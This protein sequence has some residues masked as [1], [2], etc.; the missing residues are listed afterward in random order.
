MLTACS[1]GV[2]SGRSSSRWAPS[3]DLLELLACDPAERDAR[4]ARLARWSRPR[5]RRGASTRAAIIRR[6]CATS[7]PSRSTSRAAA[8]SPAPACR[9]KWYQAPP[10]SLH[11][12]PLGPSAPAIRWRSRPAASGWTSSWRSRGVVG[13]TG[14]DVTPEQARGHIA[15]YTIF[16][17]WSARDLQA[18]EMQVGL[19]PAKAKDFASTLGPWIVTSDEL[20][21]F[22]ADDRLHLDMSAAI[23]GEEIGGD[24]PPPTWPWSFGGVCSPTPP[25]G[26]RPP[27]GTCSAPAPAAPAACS[28]YGGDTAPSSRRRS[29]R[30]TSSLEVEGIGGISN[31]IVAVSRRSRSP[32]PARPDGARARGTDPGRRRARDERRCRPK[33]AAR[34]QAL[35]SR[36]ASREKRG[37]H[38]WR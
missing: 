24:P 2:V 5:A 38:P 6:R 35:A 34:A 10:S 25:V 15:G 37:E 18:G 20:E 8:A 26:Q 30:A 1:L 17:D 27:P 16:N 4:A 13:R 22:P 19:E 32:A 11:E 36:R 3:A 9:P 14:R 23:N 29:P 12:P 28:S 21:P 7:S 33:P 31:P